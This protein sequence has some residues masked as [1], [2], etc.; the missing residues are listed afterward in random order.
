MDSTS[1][2]GSVSQSVGKPINQPP[3]CG[4]EQCYEENKQEQQPGGDWFWEGLS[5]AGYVHCSVWK[6]R[7]SRG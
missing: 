4:C 5:G 2:M 7:G 6:S 1:L 3:N